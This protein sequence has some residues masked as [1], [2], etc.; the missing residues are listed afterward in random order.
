VPPAVVPDRGGV[1][2]VQVH[3]VHQLAVD[4][5]LELRIGPVADPHRPRAAVA[6]EVRQFPSSVNSDR[7]SMPYMSC[8]GPSLADSPSRQRAFRCLVTT[9]KIPGSVAT[10]VTERRPQPKTATPPWL[11]LKS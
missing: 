11:T 8:S 2:V 5:E 9:N 3:R 1:L 7:P 4:V 10:R 6:V